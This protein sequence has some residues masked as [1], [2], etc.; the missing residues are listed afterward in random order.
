MASELRC[1]ASNSLITGIDAG[2]GPMILE[3]GGYRLRIEV[4]AWPEELGPERPNLRW[5]MVRR[6]IEGHTDEPRIEGDDDDVL[7]SPV[8]WP[9]SWRPECWDCRGK[10]SSTPSGF[11]G[12][13]IAPWVRRWPAS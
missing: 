1:D 3:S 12:A 11:R 8:L 9:P 5:E 10:R 2:E 6:M 4:L 13:G 7:A